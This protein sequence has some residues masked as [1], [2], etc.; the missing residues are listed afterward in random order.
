MAQWSR[1]GRYIF[2]LF[3]NSIIIFY[4][5]FV[6]LLLHIFMLKPKGIL[7]LEVQSVWNLLSPAWH[8]FL[9]FLNSLV[10]A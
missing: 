1:R 4:S 10:K 7:S 6:S 2:L 5:I 9:Y 3:K 8:V